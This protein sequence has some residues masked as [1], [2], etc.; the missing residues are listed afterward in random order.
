ML[1]LQGAD[2]PFGMQGDALTQGDAVGL[3]IYMAFSHC[4]TPTPRSGNIPST[5]WQRLGMM[6]ATKWEHN[7]NPTATPWDIKVQTHSIATKWQHTINPMTT[8]R[9]DEHHEVTA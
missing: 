1:P 2:M 4:A 5:R 7:I 6:N 3:M 8:P 9:D